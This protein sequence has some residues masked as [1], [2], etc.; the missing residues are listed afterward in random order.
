MC[1]SAGGWLS[2]RRARVQRDRAGA[3]A[4]YEDVA[5]G[6]PGCRRADPQRR[7]VEQGE[8]VLL[9]SLP[10]PVTPADRARIRDARPAG[11]A[12]ACAAGPVRVE[13][14]VSCRGALV[15]RRGYASTSGIAHAGQAWTSRPP[16]ALARLRPRPGGGRVRS[17]HDLMQGSHEV[18]D[19]LRIATDASVQVHIVASVGVDGF[20]AFRALQK[21][22]GFDGDPARGMVSG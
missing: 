6:V 9:R 16:T 1:Q 3:L 18:S 8:D 10:T 12:P 20:A 21:E 11:L 13:R 22:P 2:S 17:H 7:E 15:R 4:G 5:V 14:R 19:Q